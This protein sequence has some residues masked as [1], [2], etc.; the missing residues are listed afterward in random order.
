MKIYCILFLLFISARQSSAQTSVANKPAYV[1][2]MGDKIVTMQDVENM[3][4]LGYIKGINKGVSDEEMKALKEKF[5]DKVGDDKRF[6]IMVSL[7][8]EAEKKQQDK[9]NAEKPKQPAPQKTDDGFKLHVNDTA[10]NFTVQMLDG[11]K[12]SLA[13]LKGKVVLLNFWATWCAPCMMEFYD[14]PSKILAPFKQKDFVFLPISRGE[15]LATV[16]KGAADLKQKGI[17]FPVGIDPDKSIWDKYGTTGIP[18]NF[19]ID[20]HGVIRYVSV[21]YEDGGLDALAKEIKKLLAE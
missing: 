16:T 20:K 3:V 9:E 13:D 5:G 17:D 11:R 4:K 21:G 15:T 2:I 19:L 1:A 18:K 12:I 8:T 14:I 6:I 10:T 7:L